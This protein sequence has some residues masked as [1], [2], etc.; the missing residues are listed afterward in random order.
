MSNHIGDEN[1]PTHSTAVRNFGQSTHVGSSELME[2]KKKDCKVCSH[3][4][5]LKLSGKKPWLIHVPA[6]AVRHEW[7][8]L[9][10]IFVR[11]GCVGI[12]LILRKNLY[13]IFLG[14]FIYNM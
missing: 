12:V 2:M 8:A 11:T 14:I 9:S 5:K 10:V 6:A 13:I 1:H 3:L 7:R 4:I